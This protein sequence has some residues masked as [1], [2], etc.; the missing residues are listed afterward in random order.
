MAAPDKYRN[1]NEL[2]KAEPAD[3]YRIVAVAKDSKIAIIA[4]HAG[5]IEA[6]TSEL[7]RAIA[8]SDLSL[9]LF[10]GRKADHNRDLHVT[11]T[12]FDEPSG[13]ALVRQSAVVIALHGEK[14][15]EH[16]IAYLGGRDA[17]TGVKIRGQLEAA[18]FNVRTHESAELQGTHPDNICNRGATGAGVQ[19]EL[20]KALRLE[21][22]PSLQEK[23][24]AAPRKRFYEFVG[25]IRAALGVPP[26]A[27]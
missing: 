3:A 19:L 12:N 27:G 9:Y 7:A 4:P 6:G 18:G 13:V 25:A 20:S 23:G 1:F 2:R 5:A 24:R 14:D 17:Q 11:S 8:G 22:F 16:A 15:E 26:P 21:L 10:E